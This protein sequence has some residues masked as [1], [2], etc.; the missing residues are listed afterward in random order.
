MDKIKISTR[1]FNLSVSPKDAFNLRGNIGL[2]VAL[3]IIILWIKHS[4]I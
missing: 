2:F 3:V 4:I 1:S